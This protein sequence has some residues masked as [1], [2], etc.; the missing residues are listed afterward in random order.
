MWLI[1]GSVMWAVYGSII[2]SLDTFWFYFG[3]GLLY[4]VS[5]GWKYYL[6]TY[7]CINIQVKR[8]YVSVYD[9]YS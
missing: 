3:T 1:Y 9:R 8:V 4:C 2:G 5:T 6:T 7:G